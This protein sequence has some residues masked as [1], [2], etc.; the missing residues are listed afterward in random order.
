MYEPH[1]IA[2]IYIVKWR[3]LPKTEANGIISNVF[4]I[5]D[6]ESGLNRVSLAL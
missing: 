5:H 1:G 4:S 2:Y 3:I 6:S